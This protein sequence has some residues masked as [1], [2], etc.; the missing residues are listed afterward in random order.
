MWKAVRKF[1]SGEPLGD[2]EHVREWL[3]LKD[4]GFV[5]MACE[6]KRCK[7]DKRNVI[8]F[9]LL[10]PDNTSRNIER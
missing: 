6:G 9:Q 4:S 7:N 5:M 3:Q 1:R 10:N 8:V 2:V